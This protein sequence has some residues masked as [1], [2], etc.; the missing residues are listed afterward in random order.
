MASILEYSLALWTTRCELKKGK[1][2]T[3]RLT[4]QR[5]KLIPLYT[6][7]H[8]HLQTSSHLRSLQ[9]LLPLSNIQSIPINSIVYWLRTYHSILLQPQHNILS[10]TDPTSTP[11][12]PIHNHHQTYFQSDGSLHTLHI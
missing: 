5:K 7:A 6:A 12:S 4:I 10:N 11:I 8:N 2:K 1:T 3:A 9:A